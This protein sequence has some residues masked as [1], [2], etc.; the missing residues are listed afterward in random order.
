MKPETVKQIAEATRKMFTLPK[1]VERLNSTGMQATYAPP[2]E[3]KQI[4]HDSSRF[5][6]DQIKQSGFEPN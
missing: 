4:V 1:I 3:L 2:E 5:W 6:G